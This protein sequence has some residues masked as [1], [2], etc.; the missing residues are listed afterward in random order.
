MSKEKLNIDCA[1]VAAEEV[2]NNDAVVWTAE[3]LSGGW[4]QRQCTQYVQNGGRIRSI[5]SVT[6]DRGDSLSLTGSRDLNNYVEVVFGRLM[7][8]IFRHSEPSQLFGAFSSEKANRFLSVSFEI[9]V[10][11]L[12]CES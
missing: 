10:D 5:L 12:G 3:L 6:L 7:R 2:V 4:G 1:Y 9:N 11:L 8:P